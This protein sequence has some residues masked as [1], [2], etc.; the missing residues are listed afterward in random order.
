MG[1]WNKT[2]EVGIPTIDQQHKQL[3]DQVDILS[4]SSNSQRFAD[5]LK[6]L[7]D[8]VVKHFSD[9]QL[10][11]AKSQYP[12]AELHKKMHTDFL[13]VFNQL[14]SEYDAGSHNLQVALKVNKT[15]YDWL[16]SHIMV[17]DKEF[18]AYYKEQGAR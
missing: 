2:L 12:N 11:H 16:R 8:Y 6:F 5:T 10:I 15:I 1:L 17:H 3:F 14:K 4:D 13:A 18:A 9:E 7:A